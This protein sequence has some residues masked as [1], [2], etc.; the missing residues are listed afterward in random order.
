[1]SAIVRGC[2]DIGSGSTKLLIASFCPSTSCLTEHFS[3]LTEVLYGQSWK[4]NGRLD[5]QIQMKGIEAIEKY[6]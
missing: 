1:M 2:L 6:V 5:E 3:E 4:V